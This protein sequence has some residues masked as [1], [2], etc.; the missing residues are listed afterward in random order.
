[1]IYALTAMISS[2]SARTEPDP[3]SRVLATL[4]TRSVRGT[5]L[6]AAGNW[7]LA[8]DGRERL[9]FVAVARGRCWLLLPGREPEALE[10]DDVVL[11]SNTPYTVA[12]GPDIEPVD[13]MALYA[14]P[15]QNAVRI[16]GG[17]ETVMIGGGSGFASGGGAFVLDALPH[18]L[19]VER[20][21]R[22][23]RSVARTLQALRAEIDQDDLGGSLIA[24]RLA[25]ILVVE[26]VRAYVAGDPAG[27][28]GWITALADARIG[29]ALRLMHGNAARRW[30]TPVLAKEVGMSRAA[31]AQRFSDL[32]GRPPLD[33]L[34][35]WRMV[36]AERMLDDDRPVATVAEA[37]GYSSQS[38]F[39]HAFKRETG[40]TPRAR[41]KRALTRQASG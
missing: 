19:R 39:A 11:L 37:V 16:G 28:V 31:F 23:A 34:T 14:G 22:T 3:F 30:T 21:S 1:M 12:S 26:A 20:T 15:D 10:Q 36:M 27:R 25:E 17:D 18:V 5:S 8:F 6:A 29:M 4:G 9:K 2:Q 7:A 33:Y 24:D 32:V 41:G 40:R 38:A 35:R 13:G